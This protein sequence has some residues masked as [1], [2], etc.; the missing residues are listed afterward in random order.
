[1]TSLAAFAGMRGVLATAVIAQES[2]EAL[3][4]THPL[5]ARA[6]AGAAW[7]LVG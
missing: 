7:P 1:M 4:A 3:V 2:G 6:L 5:L